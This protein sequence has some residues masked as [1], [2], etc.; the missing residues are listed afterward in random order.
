[1]SQEN[2]PDIFNAIRRDALLENV[3]VDANGRVDYD[4]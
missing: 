4:V 3:V 1:M 2:E